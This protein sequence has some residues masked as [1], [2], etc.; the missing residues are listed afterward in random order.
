MKYLDE[1]TSVRM[2]ITCTVK[3]TKQVCTAGKVIEIRRPELKFL[4]AEKELEY[5]KEQTISI[6]I[7]NPLDVILTGC[8]LHLDGTL[9]KERPTLKCR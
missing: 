8:K 1:Y 4:N 2:F 3:E 6:V 5:G 9:M 7:E